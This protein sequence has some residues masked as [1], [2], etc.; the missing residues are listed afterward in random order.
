MHMMLG[1]RGGGWSG[2][3]SSEITEEARLWSPRLLAGDE[4]PEGPKGYRGEHVLGARKNNCS[5]LITFVM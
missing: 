4:D 5:S 2:A 1:R 3:T